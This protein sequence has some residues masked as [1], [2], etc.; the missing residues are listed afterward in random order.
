MFGNVN[1]SPYITFL[2]RRINCLGNIVK[3]SSLNSCKTSILYLRNSFMTFI[4]NV[5]SSVRNQYRLRFDAHESQSRLLS[6]S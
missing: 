5:V 3:P 2:L 1:D 4:L 6:M